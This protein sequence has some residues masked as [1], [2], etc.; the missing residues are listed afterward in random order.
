[1][2]ESGVDVSGYD[3]EWGVECKAV[4]MLNIWAALNQAEQNAKAKNLI[5]ILAFKRNQTKEYVVISLEEFIRLI[6]QR[7][8][9]VTRFNGPQLPMG[10]A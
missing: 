2:G 10:S 7:N 1:M 4:E 8:E 5:P 3:C 6:K 9:L